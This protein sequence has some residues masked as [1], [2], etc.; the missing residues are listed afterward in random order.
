MRSA[1]PFSTCINKTNCKTLYCRCQ[2]TVISYRNML[3]AENIITDLCRMGH[4]VNYTHTVNYTHCII[5]KTLSY[6]SR[7]EM[8]LRWNSAFVIY[9]EYGLITCMMY[10]MRGESEVIELRWILSIDLSILSH[11]T[12]YMVSEFYHKRERD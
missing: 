12:P 7:V 10:W 9:I 2:R 11:F 1:S 3:L 8:W 5:M 4:R 6:Q